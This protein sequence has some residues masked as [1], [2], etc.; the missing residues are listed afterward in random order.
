[1]VVPAPG[2]DPAAVEA[3]AVA[4]NALTASL[5]AENAKFEAVLN[6]PLV[7]AAPTA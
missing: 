1:M 7:A 3:Q 4:L 2:V 5:K 6:P